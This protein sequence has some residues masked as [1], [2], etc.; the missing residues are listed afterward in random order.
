LLEGGGGGGSV[1][2]G[3]CCILCCFVL[4]V[5]S[6]M[7]Y[8]IAPVLFG[9]GSEIARCNFG[10]RRFLLFFP[11]ADNLAGSR[12]VKSYK[13]SMQHGITTIRKGPQS[14]GNQQK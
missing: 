6:Q 3:F 9:A 8:S 5:T 4:L 1:V 12:G 7:F 10:T 11:N 14:M 2:I 13:I